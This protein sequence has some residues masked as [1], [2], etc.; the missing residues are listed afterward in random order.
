MRVLSQ[1]LPSPINQQQSYLPPYDGW[2]TNGVLSDITVEWFSGQDS[3]IYDNFITESNNRVT[4]DLLKVDIDSGVASNLTIVS[5]NT[6][7]HAP[8][9]VDV[10]Q[11]RTVSNGIALYVWSSDLDNWVLQIEWTEN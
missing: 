11:F 3:E 7:T 1:F 10:A 6:F 5:T 9:G 8:T 4:S 2:Y